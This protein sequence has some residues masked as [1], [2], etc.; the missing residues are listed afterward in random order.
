MEQQLIVFALALSGLFNVFFLVGYVQAGRAQASGRAADVTN[1]VADELG[2][3]TA[4]SALFTEL[5]TRGREDADVYESSLAL[6]R[7]DF[8]EALNREQIDPARLQGIV[9]RE[10]E[11][12]RQWRLAQADRLHDFVGSLTPSQ[13]HKLMQ[14]MHR[15][16]MYERRR[17]E[18]LQRFDANDDGELDEQER[19]AAREH[20]QK[21][22]AERE[23]RR[24][25][26]PGEPRPRDRRLRME[27]MKR[28]DTDGDRQL[29]P[30][31][32]QA[33]MRWLMQRVDKPNG[34]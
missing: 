33:I 2:L 9:D 16:T 32:R 31:E 26:G 13:R 25:Q 14:R 4:Q 15:S 1:V 10:S 18:M 3:D 12:R 24:G 17:Q 6:V 22:R 8:V 27:L 21:R 30:D 23:H 5:Q 28:F 7:Q 19:T 11:L 34:S 20:M 29:D